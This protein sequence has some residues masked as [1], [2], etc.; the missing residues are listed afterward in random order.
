MRELMEQ[1]RP[2]SGFWDLKLSPGGLVDVEFAAQYLQILHAGAGGPLEVHTAA[3]LEA[4]AARGLASTREIGALSQAWT[5]QQN[6]SQLLKLALADNTDPDAEPKGFR[7]ML[8][9]AGESRDFAGL[10]RKLASARSR[11]RRSF[12]SILNSGRP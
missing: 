1:E 3:A 11:A 5:L 12:V 8:A 6:L 4:L 7:Q 2:P 9:R 10:R